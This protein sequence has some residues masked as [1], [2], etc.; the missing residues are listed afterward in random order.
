ML[1]NQ[2]LFTTV[3]EYSRFPL[4]FPAPIGVQ[5]LSSNHQIKT[6]SLC[7]NLNFIR[8][9]RRTEFRSELFSQSAKIRG[10]GHSKTAPYHPT[11]S[12]HAERHNG[13]I[14]NSVE[15]IFWTLSLTK[16]SY[17][18]FLSKS[19]HFIG[20]IFS[21]SRCGNKCIGYTMGD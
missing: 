15:M 21:R 5:I 11:I 6:F 16:T 18:I 10:L 20:S 19:H 7:E 8:S 2:Y 9:D 1:K 17:K 3:D 13:F 4:P 12:S 14:W